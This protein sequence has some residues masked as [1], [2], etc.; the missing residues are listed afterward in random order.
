MCVPVPSWK[1]DEKK[2][3]IQ[4]LSQ[5]REENSIHG[6][7]DDKNEASLKNAR[8]AGNLHTHKKSDIYD[9]REMFSVLHGKIFGSCQTEHER[10]TMDRKKIVLTVPRRR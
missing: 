5:A 2:H 9:N 3:T 4:V 6:K 7:K 10:R 8:T 1:A